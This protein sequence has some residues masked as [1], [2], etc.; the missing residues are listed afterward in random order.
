MTCQ[1][2]TASDLYGQGLEQG[3]TQ[4]HGDG[5]HLGLWVGGAASV[6]V[7]LACLVLTLSR[8]CRRCRRTLMPQEFVDISALAVQVMHARGA[9]MISHAIS[10]SLGSSRPPS[11]LETARKG[12]ARSA[13]LA[14]HQEGALRAGQVSPAGSPDGG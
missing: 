1:T 4:G 10:L 13:M 2:W 7:A 8:R 11:Q 3:Y 6:L 14:R 9:P 5:L 12:H